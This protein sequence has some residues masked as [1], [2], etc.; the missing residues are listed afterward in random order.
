MP[1]P[2]LCHPWPQWGWEEEE[3][4]PQMGQWRLLLAGAQTPRHMASVVLPSARDVL[5]LPITEVAS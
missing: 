2:A 3:E 5:V 4:M 1:V